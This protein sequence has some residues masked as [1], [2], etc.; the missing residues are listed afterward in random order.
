MWDMVKTC[1]LVAEANKNTIYPPVGEFRVVMAQRPTLPAPVPKA[2]LT[3]AGLEPKEDAWS[4]E[5]QIARI[6]KSQSAE[7]DSLDPMQL[8]I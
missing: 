3:A 5:A 4:E 6:K 1:T 8:K 7:F 2:A